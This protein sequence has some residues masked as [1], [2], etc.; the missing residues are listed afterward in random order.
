MERLAREHAS[1]PPGGGRGGRRFAADLEPDDVI[2]SM[3]IR[4][5]ERSRIPDR[6][7]RADALRWRWRE[8]QQEAA[9]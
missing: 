2:F 3:V 8:R 6:K 9:T 4:G 1:A 5:L 7:E